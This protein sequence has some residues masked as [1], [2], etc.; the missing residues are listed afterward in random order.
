MEICRK[1]NL[2]VAP[3]AKKHVGSV[4]RCSTRTAGTD[5]R[6]GTVTDQPRPV[7]QEPRRGG[8]QDA[9]GTC[10]RLT[11][12]MAVI[13][14]PLGSAPSAARGGRSRAGPC[15]MAGTKDVGRLV[16]QNAN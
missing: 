9:G 16:E 4:A 3:A 14:K 5:S 15:I 7:H 12:L 1:C 8:R 11:R 6:I 13:L 2:V 10:P